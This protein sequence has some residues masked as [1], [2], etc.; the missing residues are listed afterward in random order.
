MKKLIFVFALLMWPAAGFAQAQR[1]EYPQQGRREELESQIVQRFLDHASI[2]L[3]LD[4]NG[5]ARLEQH[6]RQSAPRRRSL[7]Q[8]TAQLR[9]QI[10]RAVRDQQTPDAEFTRLIN[11]MTRLRD[12]EETMWKSDQ[13]SLS[14]ILTPRQHARFMVLWIRFNDQIRDMTM[15]RGGGGGPPRPR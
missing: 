10:L 4:A 1:P 3:Q 11:E 12:Q 8:N 14:R 2:E 6:L 15:R 7:A 9:G 5:R 13:E